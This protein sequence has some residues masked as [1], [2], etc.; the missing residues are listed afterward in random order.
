MPTG[1]V[2]NAHE[3]RVYTKPLL[4]DRGAV[5]LGSNKEAATPTP[6]VIIICMF[7]TV[8]S[9]LERAA[10]AAVSPVCCCISW[11]VNQDFFPNAKYAAAAMMS[12]GSSAL[13]MV[14]NTLSCRV[15]GHIYI[16]NRQFAR[17]R[18]A[19]RLLLCLAH[20]TSILRL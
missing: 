19:C 11:S 14:A 6:L 12:S 17:C 5:P 16:V 1:P 3:Q 4:F 7:A 15:H 20:V 2:R 9:R 8:L 18:R 13:N 10:S